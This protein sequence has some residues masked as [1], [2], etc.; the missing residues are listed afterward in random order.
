MTNNKLTIIKIE[1]TAAQGLCDEYG[2]RWKTGITKCDESATWVGAFNEAGQLCGV[3][4]Y[5]EEPQYF[6]R[7]ILA[8]HIEYNTRYGVLAAKQLL[9]HSVSTLPENWIMIGTVV[10]SN[11]KA[12]EFL[13]KHG[14][15]EEA[16][17]FAKKREIK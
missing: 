11:I 10:P 4:G 9:E 8:W 6:R 15:T 7:N 13:K 17:I 2:D 14:Y 12:R 16:I 1:S 5:I 3:L